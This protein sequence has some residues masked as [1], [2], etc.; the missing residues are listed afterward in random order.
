MTIQHL[1]FDCDGVLVDS[2]PLSMQ[3][4][5]EMLQEQGL[6]FTKQ[7]IASRFIGFTMAALIA[8]IEAEFRIKLPADFSIEKDR[9]LLDLYERSLQPVDGIDKLLKNLD[10]SKSVGSNSPRGRVEAA[11][12]ITGLAEYFGDRIV[13]FEDVKH[14]KPAPDI[15]LEAAARAGVSPSHC[16]VIEDSVAGVTAAAAAGCEVLGFT[17][18]AHAPERHQE[19]LRMAGAM[20][21][22]D[23]M[24]D[25]PALINGAN[26]A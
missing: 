16:L 20:A 5:W 1:I 4:D 14:G 22:F 25:L 6:N 13:T 24:T 26:H 2:E 9:R 3:V 8:S 19:A 7:E 15:Y 10:F 17:G 23:R 11:L 12:R 18:T 21:I